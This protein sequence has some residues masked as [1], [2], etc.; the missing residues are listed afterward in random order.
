[1]QLGGTVRETILGH[2][3][4]VAPAEACGLLGGHEG[5]PTVAETAI[6]TPNVASNPDEQF[7]IDPE[8]LIAGR[9]ALLEGGEELLGFY[10]S[11]PEGPP[12]PS[13]TDRE[14]A[15]WAGKYTVIATLAPNAPTLGVWED[16]GASFRS[17]PIEVV[18]DSDADST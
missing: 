11:H 9:E 10:H 7:E 17:E 15:R 5:S 14:Q 12:E 18:S 16:T 6:P 13:T 8:A 3:K 4:D 2:A 1:M